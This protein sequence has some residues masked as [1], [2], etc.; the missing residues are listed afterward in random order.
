MLVLSRGKNQSV[1]IGDEITVKIEEIRAGGEDKHI[2][3]MSVR[4]GFETPSYVVIVRSEL[5]N[6]RSDDSRT[7]E[8]AD[9]PRRSSG[10]IV[11]I[12]EA[13]AILQIQTPPK[14]PVRH[15]GTPIAGSFLEESKGGPGQQ[16]KMAYRINCVKEDRI[17][18][19]HNITIAILDFYQ[20]VFDE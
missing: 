3:G 20:F 8:V 13:R 9:R 17:A 6:K 4:L 1:I 16:P 12:P 15:N 18:V 10:A 11:D 7:A 14:I 19:C 2:A 5:L